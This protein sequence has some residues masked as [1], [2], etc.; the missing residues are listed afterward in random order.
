MKRNDDGDKKI[1]GLGRGR[2]EVQIPKKASFAFL[3]MHI[4]TIKLT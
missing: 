3:T 1:K 4:I 2:E